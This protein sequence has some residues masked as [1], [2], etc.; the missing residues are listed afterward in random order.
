MNKCKIL[1]VGQSLKIGGIE[2]ALVDQLNAI[3]KSKFEVH[4]FLFSKTGHYLP[5][6]DKEIKILSGNRILGCLGQTQ[7]ESK[8]NLINFVLR[9]VCAMIVRLI[10][11]RVF[12]SFI[13]KFI[14][15]KTE[16]DVAVSYVHDGSLKSLY[17]GCNLFVINNVVAKEKIAWIHSDYTKIKC[18]ERNLLYQKFDKVV[19]VSYAMKKNFDELEIVPKNNSYIV[20]NRINEGLIIEK[21]LKEV[22]YVIPNKFII[23]T[24]GRLEYLKSTMELCSVAKNLKALDSGFIWYFIGGGVLEDECKEYI[25][26]NGLSEQVVFTGALSNPYPIIRR[27]NVYVSG[28]KTE[29]F[30]LSILEALILGVKVI[31]KRYDAIDELLNK[32]NGIIVDTIDDM[33]LKLKECMDGNTNEIIQPLYDYNALNDSQFENLI[34]RNKGTK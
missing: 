25:R 34:C 21:S 24:V 15:I 28:S 20:Y 8:S 29:T 33:V 7:N 14:N 13:F 16:Y 19:N 27:A 9:G 18:E 11:S 12:Y 10:G 32:N 5:E 17:Y 23:V 31:A 26:S 1:F 6:L 2:R 30:G 22:P 3:D 4:L